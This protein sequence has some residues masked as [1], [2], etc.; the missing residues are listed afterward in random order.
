MMKLRIE[1]LDLSMLNVV[2]T[3]TDLPTENIKD[4]SFAIVNDDNCLVYFEGDTGTWEKLIDLE[5]FRALVDRVTTLEETGGLINQ[6]TKLN[7]TAPHIVSISVG[8][9]LEFKFKPIEILKFQPG[10]QNVVNTLITFDNGDATD[11][12]AND[13]VIFDGTMYLKST[14]SITITDSTA[15][16][17]NTLYSVPIDLTRYKAINTMEVK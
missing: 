2:A 15:L 16:G 12:D 3:M 13:Q 6:E 10:T 9:N 4:G 8:E 17:D 14:D 5:D 1:Q 7:I 11:F